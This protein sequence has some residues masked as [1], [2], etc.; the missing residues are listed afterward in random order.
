MEIT[1][2]EVCL[3]AFS[4]LCQ[5]LS[6]SELISSEACQYWI[7]ERG[8]M[9]ALEELDNVQNVDT[10]FLELAWSTQPSLERDFALH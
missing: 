1:D 2:A 9:A 10:A 4:D 8:Y 7:F 6:R 5:E 3:K